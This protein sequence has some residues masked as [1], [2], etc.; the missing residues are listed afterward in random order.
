MRYRLCQGGIAGVMLGSLV[1]G[2][3]IESERPEVTEQTQWE[4]GTGSLPALPER[5]HLTPVALDGALSGY[6]FFI[7]P[8]SLAQRG[9][10]S[11]RYTMVVESPH[12]VRNVL[13]ERVHC[14][15]KK[16]KT[17]AY[18]VS[19]TLHTVRSPQWKPIR[20]RGVQGYRALLHEAYL[21]DDGRP[22]AVAEIIQR[23]DQQP[24]GGHMGV[25]PLD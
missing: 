10:G 9:D 17:E 15:A 16:Y 1:S 13:V 22:L 25:Q 7:D 14:Q 8:A 18:A 12:S 4:T 19:K 23:L 11:I 5:A 6:Q 21:C 24:G 3:V 20:R 2:C